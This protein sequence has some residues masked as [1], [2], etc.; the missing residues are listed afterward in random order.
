[1]FGKGSFAA[2]VYIADIRNSQIRKV[3]GATGMITTVAGNGTSGFSGD[4][5]LAINATL[6]SPRG[7]ASDASGN[8]WIAD[9]NNN[10]VRKV[11]TSGVI[12]TVAGNGNTG[13]GGD[14]VSATSTSIHSPT[15][16]DVD[17][18]GNLYIADRFNF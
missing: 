7:V 3:S 15:A 10:R 14:G 18:Q 11:D 8:V 13:Y 4:D 6:K 9:T 17:A 12:R 16:V 5:Q 1:R 2:D